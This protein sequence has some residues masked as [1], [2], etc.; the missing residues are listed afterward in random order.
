MLQTLPNNAL[1]LTAPGATLP[2]TAAE[3]RSVGRTNPR[4]SRRE[5][6]LEHGM[7]FA[8]AGVDTAVAQE[9]LHRFAP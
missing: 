6:E 1:Q 7:A 4:N 9:I 8:F 2:G 3:R 5:V